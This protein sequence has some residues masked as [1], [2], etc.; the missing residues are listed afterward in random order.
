MVELALELPNGTTCHLSSAGMRKTAKFLRWEIHKRQRYLHPGFEL[1]ATD[2]VLD[3]GGN[4]G[5]FVLWAAPQVPNG[6]VVTVEP[7]PQAHSCLTSNIEKNGF[8]N[9]TALRAAVGHDGGQIEMVIYPGVEALSHVH[10]IRPTLI[11]HLFTK[12]PRWSQ[13]VTAPTLSLGRIMDEQQLDVV[14]YLKLDCEG[15]EFEILRHTE[16]AYWQRIERVAIEYH[17]S[18]DRRVDE[19]ISILKQHG[20][21]VKV[22]ANLIER[23][24]L[25]S[26]T[27]WACR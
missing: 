25:K 7:T 16:A 8:A 17:E 11:T 26:G 6:R 27:I 5:M 3:I 15:C 21:R 10:Y 14:N 18:A 4:I 22:A 19:L 20:F 13:R 24:L 2:T 9:V 1:R 23:H 12:W